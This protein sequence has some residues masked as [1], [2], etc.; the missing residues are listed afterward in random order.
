MAGVSMIAVFGG[1]GLGALLRWW[2]GSLLNPVFPTIP[3]GTVVANLTGG[4]L[5]GIASAFFTHRTGMPPRVATADHHG[6]HGRADDLLDLLAGDRGTARPAGIRVGARCRQPAPDRVARADRHRHRHGER[7]VRQGLTEARVKLP[8][9]PFLPRAAAACEASLH[10]DSPAAPSNSRKSTRPDDHFERSVQS[11]LRHR[12]VR[13]GELTLLQSRLLG[14][15]HQAR[16][17]GRREITV[18]LARCL[19]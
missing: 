10:T 18:T 9:I 19:A 13:S 8:V 2:L 12:V 3:L 11:G 7:I 15:H 14:I 6:L 1:A 4:L 16:P 5:V 17:P